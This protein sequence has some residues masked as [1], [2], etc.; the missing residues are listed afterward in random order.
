M[1]RA[2]APPK[3][4]LRRLATLGRLGSGLTGSL[5]LA[6]LRGLFAR[7]AR[8]KAL[9]EAHHAESAKR[10]L[11][12]MGQMKGAIMKLGQM[13]SYVS[14]DVPEEYRAL[15]ASLQAQAPALGFDA[16]RV[17]VER[18]LGDR[19]DALFRELECEPLAAASI[20]Q[21]HRG[22]LRDGREVAVKVQYPGVDE[23]IRAD[24][25]NAGWLY[26][27]VG[28]I[29]KNLDP[30]PLVEELRGRLLEEL[31]YESEARN[32]RAFAELYAGNPWV[33]VPGVITSHSTRRVLTSE[34]VRGRDFAW[35]RAQPD[36]L[37]Q[38]AAEVLYRFVWGSM[39]R[40]RAFNGDP[41]PG[42][43]LFHADGAV[44]FLDFGCVK[45]FAEPVARGMLLW[46]GIA[47]KRG[48]SRSNTCASEREVYSRVNVYSPGRRNGS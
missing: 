26:A 43:Y 9:L 13:A 24:L 6:K 22:V 33:R 23:A 35:L 29:Y 34:L 2:A 19:I 44:T 14:G 46:R 15:L 25:A 16:I 31:D 21:V 20:G 27:A 18:E 45:Y 42:N 1:P 8:R 37:R 3:S 30:G 5:A 47:P 28:A 11:A 38:R 40:H 41:H 17:E 7:E 48:S 36:A 12:T 39:F 4:A 32:Q 10:V